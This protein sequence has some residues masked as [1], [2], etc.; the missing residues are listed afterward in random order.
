MYEIQNNVYVLIHISHTS[1][2]VIV[3]SRPSK[4]TF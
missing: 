4:A 1:E 3:D 2:Y